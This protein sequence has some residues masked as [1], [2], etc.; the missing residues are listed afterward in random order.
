[1]DNLQ[2][3]GITH[4]DVKKGMGDFDWFIKRVADRFGEM[5]GSAKR[6]TAAA[7]LLGRGYQT[8]LPLF[9]QSSKGLQE[10]LQWA[11]K[12]DIAMG[13]K[14]VDT[15]VELAMAQRESKV[16]WLGIQ[17]M[18]AK[19]FMPTIIDVH[20]EFQA[21]AAQITDPKLT[22]DQKIDLIGRKFQKLATMATDIFISVLPGAIEQAS[23]SA[24]KIAGAF[25]KGFV[26]AEGWA[27]FVLGIW[28]LNKLTKGAL[29]TAVLTGGAKLGMKL[30]Q[31]IVAKVVLWMIGAGV[32]DS[33]I[34]T[35][36]KGG[37]VVTKMTP[38]MRAAGGIL[39]RAFGLGLVTLG[40]YVLWTE[41]D[42]FYRRG[43][44]DR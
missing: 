43:Q 40:A 5:T 27:K 39:G 38:V 17:N 13:D 19:E 7:K 16:A 2:M 33:L 35:F 20:D 24:V 6:Q 28:L 15:T 25:I 10:Q 12:Y 42:K 1:M 44:A 14:M 32:A 34:G 11:D 18:L 37:E 41:R 29:I 21:F 30:G 3:I 36:G 22:R 23:E 8:I 26:Q 9:S 31:A 4:D